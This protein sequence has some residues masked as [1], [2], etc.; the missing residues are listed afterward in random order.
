MGED[1]F[2]QKEKG[3]EENPL[4]RKEYRSRITP[5]SEGTGRKKGERRR[6]DLRS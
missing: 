6:K 2:Q 1:L 4:S 5:E 3:G